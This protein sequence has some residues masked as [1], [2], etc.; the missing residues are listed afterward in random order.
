MRV[1]SLLNFGADVETRGPKVCC[2]PTMA[3]FSSDCGFIVFSSGHVTGWRTIVLQCMV[4]EWR[5]EP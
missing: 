3:L 4:I 5:V 2:S 1:T